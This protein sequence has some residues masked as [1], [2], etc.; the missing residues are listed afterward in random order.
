[1]DRREMEHVLKQILFTEPEFSSFLKKG[2]HSIRSPFSS[3]VADKS[4]EY[5]RYLQTQR[6]DDMNEVHAETV[7][8]IQK[9]RDKSMRKF[10]RRCFFDRDPPFYDLEIHVENKV[11]RVHRVIVAPFIPKIMDDLLEMPMESQMNGVV[12]DLSGTEAKTV[13]CIIN[14]MYT[15]EMKPTKDNFI[16]VLE[17]SVRCEMIPFAEKWIEAYESTKPLRALQFV[18]RSRIAR[19]YKWKEY[20]E[21][22]NKSLALEFENL[23]LTEKF[24]RLEASELSEILREDEFGTHSEVVIYLGVIKW[25][26]HDW[27]N[28]KK[29]AALLM[30]EIRF[31]E[32]SKEELLA[33]CSPPLLKEVMEIPEIQV[34]LTGDETNK[35]RRIY[36]KVDA[37]HLRLWVSDS[38]LND[39]KTKL[40]MRSSQSDLDNK[41]TKSFDMRLYDK[42]QAPTTDNSE[43]MRTSDNVRAKYNFTIDLGNK[44]KQITKPD[45]HITEIDKQTVETDKH[46][47]ETDKRLPEADNQITDKRI[48][49]IPETPKRETKQ[50]SPDTRGS[51]ESQSTLSSYPSTPEYLTKQTPPRLPPA[52]QA[53]S[54]QMTLLIFGDYFESKE[55]QHVFR[56]DNPNSTLINWTK[57]CALPKNPDVTLDSIIINDSRNI[58]C[59]G[60]IDTK[61]EENELSLMASKKLYKYDWNKNQLQAL[62]DLRNRRV[63]HSALFLNDSLYVIGGRSSIDTASKTI[64][65]YDAFGKFRKEIVMQSSRYGVACV[66]IKK[67]I[68]IFGGIKKFD[69]KEKYSILSDVIVFNPMT[70]EWSRMKAKLPIGIAFASVVV[71]ENK[72]FL[73]GGR[74]KDRKSGKL[75]MSDKV[76]YFDGKM[77]SIHSKLNH[78]RCHMYCFVHNSS[79]FAIGGSKDKE[80]RVNICECLD[81]NNASNTWKVLKN[82]PLK[83][84]GNMIT[85]IPSL[86]VAQ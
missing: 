23:M 9:S 33:C 43:T 7:E 32:M 78:A 68:F 13:E 49:V 71:N 52:I 34:M 55:Q 35:K 39:L 79:I 5:T 41:Q 77:W 18:F 57:M 81:L 66:V 20:V 54:K 16:D 58:Y 47:P 38:E 67:R 59:V 11:Y 14:F 24:L 84:T 53:Q 85:L 48:E 28:R 80:I 60:G 70:E 25:L 37:P 69:Q 82:I 21:R 44:D 10:L 51:P 2:A 19:K 64:D 12:V 75:Q 73:I 63:L 40:N 15:G 3:W 76:Y 45:K 86:Q 27:S 30:N 46:L 42:K 31:N 65:V 1:M 83:T 22:I 72:I 62:D 74:V 26:H 8:R 50:E 56:W 4:D 17:L 36:R 61:A 29:F 6:I